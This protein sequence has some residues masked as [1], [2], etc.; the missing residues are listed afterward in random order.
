MR[1]SF[2]FLLLAL[3]GFHLPAQITQEG[4][5][6]EINSGKK[7]LGGVFIQFEDAPSKTTDEAGAF[8]LTFQNKRVGDLIFLKEI[9]KNGYELVNRKDFEVTKI[10]N[11]E[12]L[13]VDIILAKE[14][15]VDAAKKEY[16]EVSDKALYA[17]FER[18]KASL[19]R[20]LKEAKFTQAEYLSKL[21]TLQA[22]YDIQKLNLD[23]LADQF[24]RVNFDD[25]VPLY[26][27]ALE[28]FKV[29]KVDSS[30]KLLEDADLIAR[31]SELLKKKVNYEEALKET[32]EDI[33]D[34][35]DP[36]RLLAELYIVEFEIQKA[37]ALYDQLLLLDSTDLEILR[38]VASFYEEQRI[39]DKALKVLPKIQSHPEAAAWQIANANVSLG[40]TY[41][42]LGQ[43]ENALSAF[44]SARATYLRLMRDSA[45]YF[46]AGNLSA[47]YQRLGSTYGS[48]GQLDSALSYYQK[49]LKISESLVSADPRNVGFQNGLA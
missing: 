24:A 19:R 11:G 29:G 4:M 43:L 47:V 26:K 27:K 44:D 17:S 34:A 2:L 45:T 14:G 33:Q 22:R 32:K 7:P 18:E 23:R 5:A 6:R 21:D 40:D 48:L 46:Y 42:T 10:S 12:R 38:E 1:L 36:I 30:M 39:Y 49:D 16:Y 3:A 28:L 31:T 20:K 37:E 8:S 15:Y 35:I 25:V 13:G 41:T 9:R